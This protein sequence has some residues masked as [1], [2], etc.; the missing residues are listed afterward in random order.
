M[1]PLLALATIAINPAPTLRRFS[2]AL[3]LSHKWI[4]V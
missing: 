1:V 2:W 3:F 4:R